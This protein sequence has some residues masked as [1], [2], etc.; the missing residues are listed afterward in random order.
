MRRGIMACRIL[1][2]TILALVVL[3][4]AGIPIFSP[5]RWMLEAILQRLFFRQSDR[6]A[7]E[8]YALW[9]WLILLP[10]LIAMLAAARWMCA[11]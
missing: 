9:T 4:V 3:L 10:I 6:G 8:D 7:I 1:D 11:A 2:A 5:I